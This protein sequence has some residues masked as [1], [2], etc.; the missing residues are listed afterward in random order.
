MLLRAGPQGT[1][2]SQVAGPQGP[3]R[4]HRFLCARFPLHDAVDTWALVYELIP[5]VPLAA[6]LPLGLKVND[7]REHLSR[8]PDQL[9][10]EGGG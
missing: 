5:A 1:C 9:M 3:V 8:I 7:R 4:T 2:K 6:E 10:W